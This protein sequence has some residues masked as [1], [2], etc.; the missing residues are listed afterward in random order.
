LYNEDRNILRLL[1]EVRLQKK[2]NFIL[3]KIIISSDGSTDTSVAKIHGLADT[4]I[5]VLENKDRKGVARGINQI[6][7]AAESELVILLNADIAIH[8]EQCFSKLVSLYQETKADLISPQIKPIKAKKI[9]EKAMNLSFQTVSDLSKSIKNGQNVYTCYGP[10]RVFSKRL[11]KKMHVTKSIGED[12]FSYFFCIKNGFRFLHTTCTTVFFRSPTTV[13][14]YKKQTLRFSQSKKIMASEFGSD[15]V[16]KEY[17]I[18]ARLN[19]QLAVKTLSKHPI[20]FLYYFG[21][22][23][24]MKILAQ[25]GSKVKDTWD[26]SISSKMLTDRV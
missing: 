12:A 10:A 1:K 23:I 9:F 22:L 11:Y 13:Q 6:M 24:Y 20:L 5:E 2:D 3:E 19:L 14:D 21:V 15:L 16:E 17:A 18:P 25:T 26:I 8:D 7:E 4:A